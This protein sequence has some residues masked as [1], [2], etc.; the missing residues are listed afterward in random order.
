MKHD[1]PLHVT[2]LDKANLLAAAGRLWREVVSDTLEREF[3]TVVL[4]H[5]LIDSAAM[6]MVKDPRSLNGIVLT[7]NMFGDIISDE[8]SV[9]P[10]SLGLL[11]SAS[12]SGIPETGAEATVRGLYEPVHGQSVVNIF[13]WFLKLR[14]GFG[15][16]WFC[17]FD[18][19]FVY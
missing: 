18:F 3:P 4:K 6:V 16:V 12:L 7:S 15:A 9:I 8:A 2:S 17:T 13:C 19:G 1:P 11:P 10:G 14:P 5:M